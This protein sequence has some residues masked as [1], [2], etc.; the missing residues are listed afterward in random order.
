MSSNHMAD[1]HDV[2][3]NCKEQIAWWCEWQT[4]KPVNPHM[5][6]FMPHGFAAELI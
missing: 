4:R 3:K 2:H 6:G 5:L 1:Y